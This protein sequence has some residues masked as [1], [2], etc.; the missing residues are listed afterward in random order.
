[1]PIKS[2]LVHSPPGECQTL[3][4]RLSAL[5]GCTAVPARNRDALVLVTDTPSEEADRALQTRLDQ[6][7]SLI[8]LT[9]VSAF[10]PDDDLISLGGPNAQ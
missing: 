4:A 5:P 7:E 6:M 9:L 2:Y 3:A 8:A 10:Q 1:M